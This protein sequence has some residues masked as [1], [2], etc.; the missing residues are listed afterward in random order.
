MG[1]IAP[2][3]QAAKRHYG[4]HPYFTK[5]AWHVVQKYIEAFS[6]PGELV[7]DPFG[8]S[9]VTAVEAL[10]LRR[11]AI[12]SDI[13][14][15][16]NFI[17]WGIAV[18]PVDEAALQNASADI[19]DACA[20]RIGDLYKLD[21]AAIDAMPVPFWHPG[22]VPLPKDADVRTLAA[23]CCSVPATRLAT[24]PPASRSRSLLLSPSPRTAGTVNSSRSPGSSPSNWLA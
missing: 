3:K 17:T 1:P 13:S 20:A 15:L 12:H 10:V 19:R 8:G 18:A 6:R 14:P 5:R 11:R 4:S 24:L 23:G 9:G 16:A 7:L 2:R 21:Q 22:P